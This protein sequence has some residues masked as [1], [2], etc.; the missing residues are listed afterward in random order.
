MTILSII[1]SILRRAL[2]GAAAICFLF[3]LCAILF[4]SRYEPKAILPDEKELAELKELKD[5]S[6]DHDNPMRLQV[7]ADYS[8]GKN[9]DWYPKE[10]AP[11]LKV[12]VEDGKL[13]P[14]GER[15]GEEPLVLQ[16]V[17]G[18]GKYGGS[19]YRLKDLGGWRMTP[20]ALLRWSPQGY[21]LV[22]NVAKSW[23]VSDD[24]TTFTFKLR[25]GMR[26]SDGQP[27]TSA[28]ILYW[29]EA[30]Q[31][32]PVLN[33]S[34]VH[35]YFLH[36]GKPMKV[37]APDEQ[38]VVF[39]FSAP[40]SLFLERL[41]NFP[42]VCESPRHFLERFHPVRGDRKLIR[43]VMSEHNL[44]NERAV[45]SFAKARVEK[46]SL[47]PWT[48]RTESVTPPMT[49]V[50]NPYYW[51]VDAHGRQLPYVDR[52]VLNDKSMDM[53]TISVAQG[54]ATMQERYVRNQDY[55]MLMRQRRQYGY[56]L[57]HW[58]NGDGS[59][60]GVAINMN[61]RFMPGE[62]DVE[63]KAGLLADKRFRQALS[64]SVDRKAI[65]DALFAGAVDP[66]QINPLPQS[67]FH[68]DD[69]VDTFASFDPKRAEKLLDECGLTGRDADGYRKYPGGPPLLFDL[70]YC[71]FTGE[72]PG[73]FIVNDWR[74]VGINTRLRAQ[75]RSIFY[76]EKAA[77]LHD[78][79]V[80]A[81][82]GDFLPELDPRYYF[83]YSTESNFATKNALWY[84]TGGMF[85][86]DEDKVKGVKPPDDSPFYEGMK[87]YEQ[88][89]VTWSPDERK[90]I[91]RRILDLAS[92][93]VYILNFYTPLPQLAAV[94]NGFKNVPKK[95]VYSWDFLSPS[96]MGL[97]T[98]YWEN[99]KV[100]AR[101][102]SDIISELGGLTPLRPLCGNVETE[103]SPSKKIVSGTG[104]R[105][106]AGSLIK[107]GIFI[108]CVLLTVL[109]V[110][111][112]PYVGQRLMIM[113]PTLLIISVISFIVIEL[114]PGDAISSKIMQMQEQGGVADEK[115]ISDI[116]LMFRTDEPV[117]KRYTWW[118]GFDWFL[119][120][121]RKDQGL[122]QGNMGRSM[123]DLNP[124]NQK[125]GDRLLFTFLLS[126]GTI[127]FTWLVALPTGIYS[128]VRQYSTFDYIFTIGG[129]IGMCIPGFLLAL[130]LMF[131]AERLFGLNMSGLFSPEYAAQSGW[132][133][134]KV[135]DLMKHL[136]LPVLV[137]GVT[138]TAGMI[139]VMRA[140]LLDELKKPY[141]TTARAKGVRP[142]KLLIKYPLRVALNPFVSGI[143]HIFPELISGGA[144]I[145]IVMSLPTIGPMQ[146]DAVMQQ[147]M[148]LAGSMLMLLSTLSVLG[149]LVSDLLLVAVD[150]RIRMGRGGK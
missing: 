6:I 46:P 102:S 36:Q 109:L 148:Y 73:E 142:F 12:L 1:W 76:V 125:V 22:P 113:V 149:T 83:P 53:I 91:F 67:P 137:Q 128:A 11:V 100:S 94:K 147:D 70:N 131:A 93:N 81:A 59:N 68:Y 23:A 108:C 51:A 15:V 103:K 121:D 143:G 47:A 28:D 63:Q 104:V 75:E 133:F 124:V 10:E 19:M 69:F 9:G 111:R 48:I 132:S 55:T 97:E 146:L 45:Y 150:P 27:F 29:W 60:W 129:F 106:I 78:F 98:W 79:S 77:G 123:L 33:P 90:K 116:K 62:R 52:I 80:W 16:G 134:G 20:V 140:N 58:L 64:L 57:Y 21:P 135:M 107:W 18:E 74:K 85:A 71:S 136:W 139:R 42:G 126:L 88:L 17:E 39:S 86:N 25:K 24:W 84:S 49:Y 54:E 34:G 30:E 92:E 101:E 5:Q 114:P 26:W 141:V 31:T 119:S 65:T 118:M 89:K 41:T 4:S 127:I 14:V 105:T 43:D 120:F 3:L 56:Q 38:T 110:I 145:S 87:L 35:Y 115:E 7:E 130:L 32:D 66:A 2:L 144:I 95:G 96:N 8:E 82:Y 99:P 61:R 40:Y 13:P 50:R 112:S 122:L 37:E 44:I 117:W 72:G 138:G